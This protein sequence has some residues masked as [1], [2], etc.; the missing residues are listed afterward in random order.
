MSITFD[1]GV[2]DST[3]APADTTDIAT[4]RPRVAM[5][6]SGCPENVQLLAI[7][8]AARDFCR[9]TEIWQE[10][11]STTS[12]ADEDE[13]DLT[14]LHD[15]DAVIQRVRAVRLDDSE[16]DSDEADW[17][18]DEVGALTFEEAPDEDGLT[19]EADVVFVPRVS[20]EDFP[21]WLLDKWSEAVTAKALASLKAMPQKPW[22]DPASVDAL[23]REYAYRCGQAKASLATERQSG[24]LMIQPPTF[25]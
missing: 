11:L 25:V 15:Y 9:D 1:D 21:T 13:Y 17:R 14:A 7:R 19:I 22:S 16:T 8:L 20:C 3:T 24:D 23:E 5:S 2:L 4:L 6:V 12:T 10:T 18:A